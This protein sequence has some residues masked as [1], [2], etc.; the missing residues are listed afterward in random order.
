MEIHGSAPMTMA[1]RSEVVRY[2]QPPVHEVILSLVFTEAVNTTALEKLPERLTSAFT[3]RERREF[4][5]FGVT[6]GPAGQQLTTQEPQF[7]GW[8]YRDDAPTRILV[9]ARQQILIHAVRPGQWP[10]GAYAG[11]SVIQQEAREVFELLRPYYGDRR[12][13]RAGLRY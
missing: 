9:A 7:D 1:K 13:Q 10:T 2:R 12:I 4:S 5:S 3:K 8:L 11:W 6:F